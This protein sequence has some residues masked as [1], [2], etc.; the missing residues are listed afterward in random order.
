MKKLAGYMNARGSTPARL[1]AGESM[2]T[3][4]AGERGYSLRIFVEPPF[5]GP[6]TVLPTLM[7]TVVRSG[8]SL[9]GVPERND[10]GPG[11]IAQTL[12][13]QSIEAQTRCQVLIMTEFW[14][15]IT[16]LRRH[17]RE[18]GQLTWSGR[19]RW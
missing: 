17:L 18:R 15:Q 10:L 11:D 19:D 8:V 1:R 6:V 4:F 14:N 16:P 7:T 12:I 13:I 5:S 3:R 9:V 2:L